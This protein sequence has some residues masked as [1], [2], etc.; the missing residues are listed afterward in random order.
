M[1][2][3]QSFINI[4][5]PPNKYDIIPIHASDRGSFKHCR[6]RWNWSSPMRNNLVPKAEAH[7]VYMPLWFGSGIHWALKYYYDPILRRD[8]LETFRTWWHVQT[9]GGVISEDWLDVTYDHN[10]NPLPDVSSSYVP[11]PPLYK[12][13]GLYDI[14]MDADREEFERHLDLGIGMLTFYKEYAAEHDRFDVLVAEHTFSVPILTPSG[15]VMRMRDPRDGE[16]KDVHLRGTQDG[17]I[18]DWDSEKYGILEHKSAIS[19]NEDYFTKL[20]KDEQ[21]TTYLFGAEREAEI[22]DLPYKKCEFVLYNALRKAYPQPP[23][24]TKGG[25]ISIDRANESTTYPMLMKMIEAMGLADTSPDGAPYW[26]RDLK[27]ASYVNYVKEMGNEQFIVRT[28]VTRNIYERASIGYR[29]YMETCDMLDPHVRI[30]PNPTG[31][32]KCLRCPFRAPC[33][34]ADDGSDF[35]M[36]LEEDFEKNRLR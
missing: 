9:H 2:T 32:W 10:P 11:D 31:E 26:E 22:Y 27:L 28:P 33:I 6:R 16:E 20:D 1:T 3:S 19:I 35:Q 21:C 15:D 5:D 18:Q 12:V 25:K 14:L 13:K 8:P 29:I 24:I 17:I 7:G 34:A 4:P 30:Y 23:T 36:M